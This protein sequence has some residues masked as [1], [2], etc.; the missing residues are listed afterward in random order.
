[1]T[2]PKPRRPRKPRP[3]RPPAAE[4]PERLDPQAYADQGAPF[5]VTLQP[6]HAEWI[7]ACALSEGRTPENMIEKIIR[8]GYANDPTKGGTIQAGPGMAVRPEDIHKV[9]PGG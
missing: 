3:P 8:I 5:T 1:M 4:P 2:D 6:R 9:Y 7:R